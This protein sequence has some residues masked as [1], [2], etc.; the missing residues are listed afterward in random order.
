MS[1][2]SSPPPPIFPHHINP[3][4]T[5]SHRRS[6]H[7]DTIIIWSNSLCVL[8]I[9]LIYIYI[10]ICGFYATRRIAR[11][12]T[13]AGVHWKCEELKCRALRFPSREN[14]KKKIPH[15][16]LWS[17]H[18]KSGGSIVQLLRQIKKK[19]KNSE[20]K[21]ANYFGSSGFAF[22]TTDHFTPSIVRYD[23]RY[24]LK[25]FYLIAHTTFMYTICP[26]KEK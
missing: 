11:I 1:D 13:A 24:I 4:S 26:K 18:I 25:W 5:S 23:W 20:M 14:Q 19:N 3:L 8:S 22:L 10:C 15:H 21:S 9:S 2:C 12:L 7:R 17:P 6:T 16:K